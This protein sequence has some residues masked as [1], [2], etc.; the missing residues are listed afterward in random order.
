L[1]QPTPEVLESLREETSH[2]SRLVE[3]LQELSQAE[4]GRLR[5]DRQLF[6]LEP[7]ISRVAANLTPRAGGPSILV[8][9][10]GLPD[11]FADPERCRQIVRNLVENAVTHTPEDGSIRIH[12]EAG[13]GQV[14]VEVRDTGSGIA[15]EHV[16]RVFERFYRGDASRARATGGAGLGLAIVKQLVESQGGAVWVRSE[17][18]RGACFGFSLPTRNEESRP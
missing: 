12:A 3:D 16:D 8:D 2:L 1:L 5:F 15:P 14:R 10:G 13:E 7:E 6:P 9:A 11:V 18:G 17:P 4:A